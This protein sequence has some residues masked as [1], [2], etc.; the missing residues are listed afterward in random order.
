MMTNSRARDRTHVVRRAPRGA[1]KHARRSFFVFC[2]CFF[3]KKCE[4]AGKKCDY[5]HGETLHSITAFTWPFVYVY[6]VT[7]I[8]ET[9][10]FCIQTYED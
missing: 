7:T 5:I 8:A 4:V 1:S 3:D 6:T 2:F 9:G 10:I